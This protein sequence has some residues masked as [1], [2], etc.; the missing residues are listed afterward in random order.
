MRVAAPWRVFAPPASKARAIALYRGIAD[1]GDELVK[2]GDLA[3][4]GVAT[5]WGQALELYKLGLEHVLLC[6]CGYLGNRS[7]WCSLSWDGLNGRGLHALAPERPEPHL[8]PWKGERAG[9]AL[10]LGQVPSDWAVKIALGGKSYDEWLTLTCQRL[11][12]LG[13]EVRYRA[14]PEVTMLDH[15]LTKQPPSLREEL[16]GAR[17]AVTLNSTAA[18]EAV[19][20]GVPTWVFDERGSMAAP[21]AGLYSEPANRREW[22]NDLARRQWSLDELETGRAWRA[23]RSLLAQL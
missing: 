21:V 19:C 6:E 16:E 15:T 14:H 17:L 1:A 2:M 18:I 12:T 20:A 8:E 7:M 5:N 10:V 23:V 22:V 4:I 11:V 3:D 13:H 9:Y